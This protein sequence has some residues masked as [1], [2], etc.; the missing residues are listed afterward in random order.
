MAN[1]IAI[2]SKGLIVFTVS[3]F[4]DFPT[5]ELEYLITVQIKRSHS[6]HMLSIQIYTKSLE[7]VNNIKL[8]FFASHMNSSFPL[9][10]FID[11]ARLL[12]TLE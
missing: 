3:L 2:V 6:I 7:L 9:C 12:D 11:A 5:V 4:H 8:S 10:T 1:G